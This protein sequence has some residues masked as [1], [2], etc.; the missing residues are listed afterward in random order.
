M[1]TLKSLCA[2]VLEY[3]VAMTKNALTWT[4]CFSFTI[5]FIQFLKLDHQCFISVMYEWN[6]VSEKLDQFCITIDG[7][8]SLF[9]SGASLF[10]P[11][12]G[13]FV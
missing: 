8:C 5:S 10:E 6:C 3:L 7:W 4:E 13:I 9:V 11:Y 12:W 2:D 1:Q